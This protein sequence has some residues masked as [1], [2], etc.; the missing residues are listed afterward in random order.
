MYG[1][2]HNKLLFINCGDILCINIYISPFIIYIYIYI[3]KIAGN[4]YF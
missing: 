4:F 3:I 1:I 2:L